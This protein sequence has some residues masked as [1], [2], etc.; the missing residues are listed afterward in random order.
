[1]SENSQTRLSSISK[2]DSYEA[3][4][5]FWDT[6]SLADYWE[7]GYDVEFEIHSTAPS[8][9]QY[10]GWHSSALQ[11]KSAASGRHD[12]DVDQPLDCRAVACAATAGQASTTLE[13]IRPGIEV[14]EKQLAEEGESYSLEKGEA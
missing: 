14:A 2:A 13:V 9:R 8:Q 3:M 5:E 10:R 12:R 1:M 7:Q 6:H 4:G 11:Q